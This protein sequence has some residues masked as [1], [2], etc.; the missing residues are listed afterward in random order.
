MIAAGRLRNEAKVLE[1]WERLKSSGGP[2]TVG[3]YN[4]LLD[5]YKF[6]DPSK[7]ETLYNEMKSLGLKGDSHTFSV[8]LR[9]A[10]GDDEKVKSILQAMESE[11]I[12]FDK[13]VF[14]TLIGHASTIGNVAEVERLVDQMATNGIPHNSRKNFDI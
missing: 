3:S 4:V 14:A 2:L 7:V 6:V 11:Q 9:V 5:S 10:R 1:Y 13:F 12:P 8:R